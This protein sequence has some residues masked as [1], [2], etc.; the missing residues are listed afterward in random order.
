MHGQQHR[1]CRPNKIKPSMQRG[2]LAPIYIYALLA[3][4]PWGSERVLQVALLSAQ[5]RGANMQQDVQQTQWNQVKSLIL[6][7]I[8]PAQ[9]GKQCITEA[10]HATIHPDWECSVVLLKCC[11]CN[12]MTCPTTP[13]VPI[14]MQ[15]AP[16]K[17]RVRSK[18]VQ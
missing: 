1:Q 10:W 12:Q 7:A 5:S 17:P 11:T 13:A 8:L 18:A 15:H 9:S 2:R 4:L 14:R 16:A 3:M 6:A